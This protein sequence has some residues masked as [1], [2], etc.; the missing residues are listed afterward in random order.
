MKM[1]EYDEEKGIVDVPDELMPLFNKI[2]IQF[3]F[4]AL[5]DKNEMLAVCD[6]MQVAY[7]FFKENKHLL[8]K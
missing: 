4:V 2:G 7:N 1:Y 3:N 8:E 5:S 6:T